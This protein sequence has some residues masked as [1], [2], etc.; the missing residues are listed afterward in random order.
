MDNKIVRIGSMIGAIAA[1]VIGAR[2]LGGLNTLVVI[3]ALLWAWYGWQKM[4]AHRR[5][6]PPLALSS[7]HALWFVG[8][9]LLA[10]LSGISLGEMA[11]EVVPDI[12]V[13]AALVAWIWRSRSKASLYGLMAYE[14]ASVG[15]NGY[16]MLSEV[17]PFGTQANLVAHMLLRCATIVAAELAIR[18]SA[19]FA[20]PP[21]APTS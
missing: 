5:L 14:V 1:G 18:H 16:V 19:E 21:E 6:G 20:I 4:G 9:L 8:G 17:L 11:M 12:L 10:P 15:Y 3:A 13:T 2:L 7:A